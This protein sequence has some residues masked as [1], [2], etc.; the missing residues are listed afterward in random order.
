[1]SEDIVEILLVDDEARNLD[2][3]EAVLDDQGYRLLR[4][5]DGDA[6][7]RML[8]EHDVAA[9]ILDIKM[10]Q[11]DGLELAKIIK[12]TKRFRQI[13]ILFLTAHLTDEQDIV[14][15]YGAGAVDYLTKPF[16]PAIVRQKIAVFADLH[17]KTRA[18]ADLNERLEQRVSE[19]TAEL[20][21][22]E[23]ALRASARQKDE[24]LATLAHEL[25]NPLAPLRTGIDL[26]L[27][28][29]DALGPTATRTLRIM[30]RQVDH[31][32]RLIA[33]LLDVSRIDR[34][35]LELRRDRA[36]LGAL[37]AEVAENFR[38]QFEQREVELLVTT[39]VAV[40]ASVDATRVS[41]VIGNLLHNAAKF[42]P[43]GGAVR[44]ELSHQDGAAVVRV[45]DTGIGVPTH[46]LQRIFEMFA[47]IERTDAPP[48]A[49]AG[50]GLA[51]AKRLAELHGGA[52]TATSEGEDRGTTFT[53][54]LP[55]AE[56]IARPPETPPTA[57]PAP[58]TRMAALEI[59]VV[60]DNQDVADSMVAW[61]ESHGHRVA[62]AYTGLS[63]VELVLRV[64]PQV[65]LCDIG[66]PEIDGHEVCARIRAGAVGFRPLMVAI[67]GWDKEEDRARSRA[68]G[69]DHHLVKPVSIP[70]LADILRGAGHA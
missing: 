26:L 41:Q 58:R 48:A 32:V 70:V 6:A 46:Q 69:F 47:Q 68:A 23:R 55:G 19:R 21:R 4:A 63:G 61:L 57:E 14:A 42:T 40:T 13:P 28:D 27:N 53:L 3:L 62:V 15:G 24:F 17:R 10:P 66:L 5:G 33:D 36:D 9:I 56:L 7:L 20:E 1:M 65:V 31:L 8:L 39:K 52:L 30:D 35:V 18:L 29:E 60:E 45:K 67:S 34:G 50:I 12:G 43:R 25:R 38:P 11:L 51:L 37:I 54:T 22:S 49:G 44:V 64:R 59:A 2:A 16:S